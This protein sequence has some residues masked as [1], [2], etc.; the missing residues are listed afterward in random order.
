MITFYCV[1]FET[2]PTWIA[3]SPYLYPTRTGW[4]GYTPKHWVPFSSPPTTHRSTME[5][6]DAASPHGSELSVIAGI[7]LYSPW[8]DHSTEETCIAEQLMPSTV[9]YLLERVYLARNCLPGTCPCGNMLIE[10][11]P[12]SGPVRHNIVTCC[13]GNMTN[14]S[15]M[16]V[17]H[18]VLFG[19]S[20]GR[21]TLIHL[22][23]YNTETSDFSSGS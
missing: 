13:L 22:E 9:A 3:R 8:F 17:W 5:V 21:A 23:I 15:W 14:N 20:F 18:F 12:S 2:R 10:P 19:P 1:R 6:F 7:L 11:L 16:L 4:P